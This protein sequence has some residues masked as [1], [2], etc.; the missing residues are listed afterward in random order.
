MSA[1]AAAPEAP[2]G[3]FSRL[4]PKHLVSALITLIIVVGEW[5]YG[6]LGG[7]DRLAVALGTAMAAEILFSRWLLGVWP[8]SLLSAYISG[9]SL[10]L[11][12]KP[13]GG[14]LWPFALGAV[15]S[16]GSKYVLRYRG[17][18]LWN[19]TN[20]GVS[21]LVLLAAPKLAVLSHEWGNDL[22]VNMVIWAIGLLVVSRAKLLHVSLGYALSFVVFA[23]LRASLIGGSF[24]TE[25][26]PL[27]GPMY[28]LFVFFMVTDP[29]T[30][31]RSRNG[32][33]LVVV[34][35]AALEAGLRSASDFGLAWA[36][37]FAPAPAFFALAIVGPLALLVTRKAPAPRPA[38]AA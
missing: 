26:A 34:L 28:Q 25:V 13:A 15:I 5:Q 8:A 22:R 7:Y 1:A 18:H 12:L 35:I 33:I 9:N 23:S 30:T 6:V 17:K 32:R 24:L 27:T 29:P 38:L 37:P 19:P 14:L 16:I 10:A 21:A 31:V 4:S 20:F 2:Q 3:F 11:L 36:A